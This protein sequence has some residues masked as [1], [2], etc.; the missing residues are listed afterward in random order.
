M[1]FVLIENGGRDADV[2]ILKQDSLEIVHLFARGR[3]LIRAASMHNPA[4]K[5]NKWS[6]ARNKI[7][8]LP[9]PIAEDHRSRRKA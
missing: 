2:L 1:K 4:A 8:S 3:H 9:Q 6:Q 5:N 7:A